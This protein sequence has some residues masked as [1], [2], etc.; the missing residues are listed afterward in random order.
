VPH[1]STIGLIVFI[2]AACSGPAP[3]SSQPPP[4]FD[5]RLPSPAAETTAFAGDALRA[6]GAFAWWGMQAD[7]GAN[8]PVATHL[9]AGL[10]G[11]PATITEAVPSADGLVS[12]FGAADRI[13]IVLQ[14]AGRV[15]VS[16]RNVRDGS[17]TA[18]HAFAST[19]IQA[20]ELDPVH[21]VAYATVALVGGGV[22]IRRLSMTTDA[23]A[24]LISLDRRFTPDGIPTERFDIAVDPDGA[25][26]AEACAKADGCRLW[27]VAAGAAAAPDPVT[28]TPTPPILCRIVGATRSWIVAYDDAA[29]TADTGDAA[30]PVRAISRA[31]GSSHLVTDRHVGAGRVIE[32]EGGTYVVASD[33][34][35]AGA[36]IDVVTFDVASGAR[37]IHLHAVPA[38]TDDSWLAV[39]PM[40][41]PSPLVLLE[42]TFI[43]STALPTLQGRLL[44]LATDE[45]T[46][47]PL[48]TSGWR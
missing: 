31:D 45:V 43:E 29:C 19:G 17:T 44:D 24:T 37:S 2:V 41:L 9:S 13:A 16:F 21:D 7:G 40:A 39:S 18:R 26:I 4:S 36:T 47:L 34:A 15:T 12:V 46:L 10:V 32:Y 35:S 48:G 1:R 25:L 27:T 5:D 11:H 3:S 22:E 6:S 28:L 20:L 14:A 33:G 30:L 23:S 42:P 38:G 8:G